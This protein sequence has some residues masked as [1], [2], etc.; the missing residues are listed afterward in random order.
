MQRKHWNQPQGSGTVWL[1]AVRTVSFPMASDGPIAVFEQSTVPLSAALLC[2]SASAHCS[3]VLQA[4]S[5]SLSENRSPG[6]RRCW[7]PNRRVRKITENIAQA[8]TVIQGVLPPLEDDELMSRISE[9]PS[10]LSY[11]LVEISIA[12]QWQ[13][14]KV[15]TPRRSGCNLQNS[16]SLARQGI[17]RDWY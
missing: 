2:C 10:S 8:S 11:R 7:L 14:S 3:V 13:A 4:K 1:R 6:R 9:Q 15:L 5:R 16:E 12:G 17:K